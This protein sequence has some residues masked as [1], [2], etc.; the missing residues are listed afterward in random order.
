MSFLR[1]LGREW[2]RRVEA[3]APRHGATESVRVMAVSSALSTRGA[4]GLSLERKLAEALAVHD[5]AFAA[6]N[7]V[8]PK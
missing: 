3:S 7:R 1:E 5:E 8:I 4:E 6:K 2:F